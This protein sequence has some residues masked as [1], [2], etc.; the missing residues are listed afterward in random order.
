MVLIFDVDGTLLDT[1]MVTF[2]CVVASF[3]K[4][5]P[6]FN[7]TK[8]IIV[9]FFGPPIVQRFEEVSGSKQLALKLYDA[10]NEHFDLVHDKI[11]KKFMY[12][13]N[14][15]KQLKKM[16]IKLAVYSNKVKSRIIRGFE[17]VNFM[18]YFDYILGVDEVIKPK[19]DPEGIF[20]VISVFGEDRYIYIGDSIT[21]IICANNANIESIGISLGLYSCEQ[22]KQAN[23]SYVVEDFKKLLEVIKCMIVS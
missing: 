7:L 4:V 9:S 17:C 22:L 1:Y 10:Y 20:K 23:A 13:E 14:V 5:L 8:D 18:K 12:S 3:K 16:N 15:L 11:V 2:N 21:D 6:G 19:P